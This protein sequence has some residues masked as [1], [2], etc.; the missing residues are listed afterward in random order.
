M[1][2]D[3]LTAM[4]WAMILAF[5]LLVL[6]MFAVLALGLHAIWHDEWH[7]ER[8]RRTSSWCPRLMNWIEQV[9]AKEKIRRFRRDLELHRRV[10]RGGDRPGRH[11]LADA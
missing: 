4:Q 3:N 6:A 1:G 8:R 10:P 2:N 11:H 9:R 5:A 7:G